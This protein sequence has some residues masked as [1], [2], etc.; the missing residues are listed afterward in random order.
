MMSSTG[1]TTAFGELDCN[2]VSPSRIVYSSW[3]WEDNK[4]LKEML[5]GPH[6]PPSLPGSSQPVPISYQPS[7][8]TSL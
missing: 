4:P 7:A 5:E 3:L 6:S 1:M 8:F 2:N